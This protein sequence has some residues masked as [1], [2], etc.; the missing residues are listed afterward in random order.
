MKNSK[1]GKLVIDT[2]REKFTIDELWRRKEHFHQ[3]AARLPFEEK[4]RM[5]DHLQEIART[6]RSA[7]KQRG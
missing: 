4:M 2:G 1:R 5:L 6:I 3:S 7:R